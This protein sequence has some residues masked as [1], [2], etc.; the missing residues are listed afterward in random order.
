LKR[1][2]FVQSGGTL[3]EW[4]YFEN[5]NAYSI[6]YTCVG[7]VFGDKVALIYYVCFAFGKKKTLLIRKHIKF[8]KP[9]YASAGY[10][11]S[12]ENTRSRYCY[13]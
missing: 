4:L 8:Y 7:S 12:Q 2:I 9:L 1:E 10:T 11:S 6:L 3:L 5:K 13:T